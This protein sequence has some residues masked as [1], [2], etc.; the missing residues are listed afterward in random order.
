MR[1]A[2][3]IKFPL[4]IPVF[5]NHQLISS[6]ED[7]NGAMELL[8]QES[9][10]NTTHWVIEDWQHARPEEDSWITEAYGPEPVGYDFGRACKEFLKSENATELSVAEF[11]LSKQRTD[12]PNWLQYDVG[13]ADAFTSHVQGVPLG[14]TVCFMVPGRKQFVDFLCL[15]LCKDDFELKAVEDAISRTPVLQ[16]HLA[17]S[18]AQAYFDRKFCLF[19]YWCGMRGKCRIECCLELDERT[20]IKDDFCIDSEAATCGSLED[21]ARINAKICSLPGKYIAFNTQLAEGIL[22]TL[23]WGLPAVAYNGP[24]Q[25]GP[26]RRK[27]HLEQAKPNFSRFASGAFNFEHNVAGG[28]P[29]CRFDRDMDTMQWLLDKGGNA[30]AIEQLKFCHRTDSTHRDECL[31]FN[32]PGFWKIQR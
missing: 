24:I 21:E 31:H 5:G 3:H 13:E 10:E 2:K 25:K 4:R 11:I 32:Q 8:T 6:L 27:S 15:R 12:H 23:E 29:R 20:A 16:V 22:A 17:H 30:V 14:E 28:I 1:F 19:E 7:D 26:S 9:F 18:N